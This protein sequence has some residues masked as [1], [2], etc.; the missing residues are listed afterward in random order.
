MSPFEI[1]LPLK[2][3][4]CS[5]CLDQTSSAEFALSMFSSVLEPNKFPT[6]P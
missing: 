5:M 3:I 6:Q 1:C 2:K 4:A